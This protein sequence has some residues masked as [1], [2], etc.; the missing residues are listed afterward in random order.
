MPRSRHRILIAGLLCLLLGGTA[1][2]S[3]PA[4]TWLQG[5]GRWVGEG[6]VADAVYLVCGAQDQGRRLDAVVR[7]VSGLPEDR[8]TNPLVLVGNDRLESRWSR[9]EQRNLTM[10]EWAQRKLAERLDDA[11]TIRTVPG[12][13]Y[14]TD[15]EMEA[16]ADYVDDAF[17]IDTVALATSRFHIR[18]CLKRFT[19]HAERDVNVLV[20]PARGTWHDRAPWVAASELLKMLRDRLGLARSPWVSRR[21]WM[22]PGKSQ[23]ESP[24]APPQAQRSAVD[25]TG[26]LAANELAC[27]AGVKQVAWAHVRSDDVFHG[28]TCISQGT[29][30][31]PGQPGTMVVR[32]D[33][34]HATRVTVRLT[35]LAKERMQVA[36]AHPCVRGVMNRH[37]SFTAFPL[38]LFNQPGVRCVEFVP[39]QND[40]IG[41]ARRSRASRT[42]HT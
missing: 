3:W 40:P 7:Y 25:P 1:L 12:V 14:G 30:Q 10:A 26:E 16:L 11:L 21:G 17:D 23:Q 24:Q 42:C 37:Q 22:A 6:Q 5:R 27:R 36:T 2:L 35:G 33:D 4:A 31:Q 32:R 29:V 34:R 38:H 41:R 18:R 9:E 39:R 8:A 15:G 13:F 19:T 28:D 20:V